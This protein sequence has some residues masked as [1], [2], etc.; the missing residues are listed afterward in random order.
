MEL[1]AWRTNLD[2][3]VQTDDKIT[4]C[5][6]GFHLKER[7]KVNLD[8]G[9]DHLHSRTQVLKCTHSELGNILRCGNLQRMC[10]AMLYKI[11]TIS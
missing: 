4:L 7:F 1:E 2:I 6:A 8:Q 11:L 10:Y 5:S 9:L 3:L